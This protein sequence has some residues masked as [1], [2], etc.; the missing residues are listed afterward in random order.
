MCFHHF[1]LLKF[2]KYNYFK[3]NTVYH[4]YLIKCMEDLNKCISKNNFPKN[5]YYTVEY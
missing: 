5:M 3:K 4:Y 1:K 2:N